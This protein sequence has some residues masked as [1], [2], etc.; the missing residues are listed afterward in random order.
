MS[1]V[2]GTHGEHSREIRLDCT[3]QL[4]DSVARVA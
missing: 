3:L 1:H 4:R 2:M